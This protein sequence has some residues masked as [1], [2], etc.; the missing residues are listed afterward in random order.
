MHI[1]ICRMYMYVYKWSITQST[2]KITM[3]KESWEQKFEYSLT[4]SFET[5]CF[6]FSTF[7]YHLNQNGSELVF[8]TLYSCFVL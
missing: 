7:L 3:V 4:D 2:C 6:N 5:I 1:C 8:W